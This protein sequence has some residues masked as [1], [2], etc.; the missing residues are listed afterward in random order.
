M[1]DLLHPTGSAR[2]VARPRYGG[3]TIRTD[4]ARLLGRVLAAAERHIER[5]EELDEREDPDQLDPS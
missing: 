3:Q 2:Y 1:G 4:T 5:C